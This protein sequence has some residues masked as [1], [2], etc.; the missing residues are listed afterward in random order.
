MDYAN[1]IEEVVEKSCLAWRL[2]EQQSNEVSRFEP[3]QERAWQPQ[4]QYRFP[5]LLLA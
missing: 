4:Q 5:A 3:Q 2:L 1:S